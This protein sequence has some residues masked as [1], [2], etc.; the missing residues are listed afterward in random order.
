MFHES[1]LTVILLKK[2]DF[3]GRNAKFIIIIQ[4]L[5]YLGSLFQHSS[6]C[7]H[8]KKKETEVD[9]RALSVTGIFGARSHA[10]LVSLNHLS[11]EQFCKSY[12]PIFRD[13]K[14]EA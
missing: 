7:Q 2:Y 12:V 3:L 5:Y 1:Y 9:L 11:S 8:L 4:L 14:S 13:N 6:T 10:S